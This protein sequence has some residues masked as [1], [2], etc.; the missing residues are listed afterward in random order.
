MKI[1]SIN[2]E[3]IEILNKYIPD[4]KSLTYTSSDSLIRAL[5][6]LRSTLYLKWI[7]E[8]GERY[9]KQRAKRDSKKSDFDKNIAPRILAWAKKNLK[10]VS[11]VKFG[12]CRDRGYREIAEF[13]FENASVLSWQLRCAGITLVKT[14]IS[15]TNSIYKIQKVLIDGKWANIKDLIC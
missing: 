3:E 6:T 8:E 2:T 13:D 14:G 10:P 12:G 15:T 7:E 5:Q 4:W 11:I 9:A 1:E